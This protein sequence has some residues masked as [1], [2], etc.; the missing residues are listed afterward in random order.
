MTP[1]ISNLTQQDTSTSAAHRQGISL[2]LICR[3]VGWSDRSATFAKFYNRPLS[4]K[5]NFEK[6]NS[7]SVKDY[8]NFMFVIFAVLKNLS[9]YLWF[10]CL[11]N[12]FE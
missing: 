8:V 2:E 4:D 5:A 12:R 10:F 11:T 1:N 3:T 6:N 7:K 9:V